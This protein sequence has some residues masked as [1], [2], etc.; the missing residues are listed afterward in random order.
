VEALTVAHAAGVV[1]RDLK[2]ENVTIR[3]DRELVDV[4]DGSQL[5]GTVLH[6]PASDVPTLQAE[7]TRELTEALR[8]GS[9]AIRR[10]V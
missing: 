6:R 8:S 3:A 2:P 5:W 9:R 1:H 7:I 10:S 4:E